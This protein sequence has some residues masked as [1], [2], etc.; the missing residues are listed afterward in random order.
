LGYKPP[1]RRFY[2]AHASGRIKRA[3]TTLGNFL[4]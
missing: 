4:P 1:M 3:V 2:F